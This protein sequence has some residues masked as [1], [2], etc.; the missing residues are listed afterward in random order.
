V[1]Q[2]RQ[3][4]F[5][6]LAARELGGLLTF[7][8]APAGMR[9]LG[10]LPPG[11]DDTAM[12]AEA[13]RR[14][15]VVVPMSRHLE[16]GSTRRGFMFGYAPYTVAQTRAGLRVLADVIRANRDPITRGQSSSV[17]LPSKKAEKQGSG[18]DG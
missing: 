4:T 14:G 9:L 18:F 6:N 1:H 16:V 11:S 7:N 12:A 3:R 15:V 17:G 13:A 5:L 10:W 2:E 8:E